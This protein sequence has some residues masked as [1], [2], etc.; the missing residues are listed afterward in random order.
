MRSYLPVIVDFALVLGGK[1]SNLAVVFLGGVLIARTS[2]AGEYGLFTVAITLVLLCDGFIGAPMDLSA[3]RFFALHPGE[4]ERARRFEALT[5]QLKLLLAALCVPAVLLLR[6]PM[7]A[8]WPALAASS[9]PWWT[10]LTALGG[11]LAARSTSTALQNRGL[12][13]RYSAVDLAQGVLRSSGFIALAAAHHATASAFVLVYGAASLATACFGWIF[14]GQ[15]HLLGRWPEKEDARQMLRYS[16]YTAGIVIMA[17]LTGRGDL[18]MLAAHTGAARSASYGLAAQITLILSQ[19]AMYASVLTQPR[20]LSLQRQGRLRSLFA[21][22]ALLV[23]GLMVI[24]F[25][26]WDSELAAGG[27]AGLLGPSFSSSAPLVRI[28]LLG[29]LLDWL[30][31][32]V[33]LTYCIQEAPARAFAGECAIASLFL[34]AG[35]LFVSRGQA[36]P[37]E[38][39]VAWLSVLVRAAK[40]VFYGGLFLVLTGA[41]KQPAAVTRG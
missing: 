11:L 5:L 7:A 31:L 19:V 25:L 39:V 12:F 4:T 32:P 23:A 40:V 13:R 10:S 9:L 36:W 34:A 33:A 38:H 20:I 24:G 27:I 22:N 30:V 1:F 3:V 41:R 8:F 28:L 21:G 35:A 17:T 2:G 26:A 15:S 14:L 6:A 29:A 37:A 16:G 18:L